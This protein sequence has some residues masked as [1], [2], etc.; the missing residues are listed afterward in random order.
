MTCTVGKS[1]IPGFD[2]LSEALVL[3]GDGGAVAVWAPTGLAYHFNSK[4]LDREFFN[5]AFENSTTIL[6]DV[7]LKALQEYGNLGGPTYLLD[8]YNL[9]GDPALKM[10]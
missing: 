3:K 8:I 10:R 5:A 2:S 4:T 9:Q 6:G 7:I 1:T